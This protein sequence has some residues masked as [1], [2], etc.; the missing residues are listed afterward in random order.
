M[1]SSAQSEIIPLPPGH[2]PPYD[3]LLLADPF[4]EQL[5]QYAHDGQ[6]YQALVDTQ[7]VGV[8]ILKKVSNEVLE[9][10]NIAVAEVWQ[11]KGIGR[12]LLRYAR[13]AAQSAGY[14]RLRIATGNS[15]IGQLALYQQEGFEISHIDQDYFV[16]HY[17]EPI[18]ENGIQCRHRIVLEQILLA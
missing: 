15:S 5:A 6:C 17:P 10:K 18:Y 13:K 8:M 2:E 4:R 16:H 14:S 7:V 3:L 1:Q 11:G 12:Q 9:S